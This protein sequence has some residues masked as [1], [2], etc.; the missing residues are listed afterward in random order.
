MNRVQ[1]LHLKKADQPMAWINRQE[2]AV[3]Y[4]KGRVIWELGNE[5]S[6][7]V[8][9]VNRIG[10]RSQIDIAPIIASLGELSNRRFIPALSNRLLFRRDDYRCMYC[11]FQFVHDDLSRDHIIPRAQGGKDRWENVVASCKRC[12]HS[13]ADRTPEQAGMKLLA[14]P[15]APNQF[16]FLYLANRNIQA[17]QME[18][19]AS[20][21][22]SK[23]NWSLAA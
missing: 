18:Y 22:S 15:F 14:V 5:S 10:V 21:F 8:G 2:A 12:N 20:S 11:G 6:A 4:A 7:I 16:E 13:K 17:D 3:L 19:L 1:I 9:G 23:R